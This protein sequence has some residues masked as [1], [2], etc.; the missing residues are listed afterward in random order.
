MFYLADITTKL[1]R[2]EGCPCV[3]LLMGEEKNA[4]YF[5]VVV[6]S[7]YAVPKTE[8]KIEQEVALRKNLQKFKV[9]AG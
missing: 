7:Q 3:Q 6:S 2:R 5:T 9:V 4:K 1:I 8:N